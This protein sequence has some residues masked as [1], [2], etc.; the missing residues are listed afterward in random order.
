M[1][2]TLGKVAVQNLLLF[3]F[4]NG[5]FESIWNRDRIDHV[6]I[7]AAEELGVEN[8]AGYYEQAGAL[9][10]MVQNHLTQLLTLVAMEIP[11]AFEADMI[12]DEK[13]NVL[14]SMCPIVSE[15]VVSLANTRRGQSTVV[16]SWVIVKSGG[17]SGLQHGNICRHEGG[18]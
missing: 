1:I 10:D 14:R 3:R 5:L 13:L 6:Q 4:A 11:A 2:T 17:A 8:R 18:H 7:T 9:R 15:D 16:R 12:R